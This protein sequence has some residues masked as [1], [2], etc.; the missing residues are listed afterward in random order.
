[1]KHNPFVFFCSLT[2]AAI[3]CAMIA[4]PPAHA[5]SAAEREAANDLLDEGYRQ[6]QAGNMSEAQSNFDMALEIDPT[7]SLAHFHAA[8]IYHAVGE[9]Q[10]M[11]QSWQ[12]AATLGKGTAHG[13]KAT[14]KLRD[15]GKK[16]DNRSSDLD[17]DN[18]FSRITGRWCSLK[19]EKAIGK[20]RDGKFWT[21]YV[22]TILNI[23]E[24]VAENGYNFVINDEP[25]GKEFYCHSYLSDGSCEN[26][27]EGDLYSSRIRHDCEREACFDFGYF[28]KD[29][30]TWLRISYGSGDRAVMFFANFS[31]N[32][33]FDTF[34]M[35]I[36]RPRHNMP[37]DPKKFSAPEIY[38]GEMRRCE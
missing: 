31:K 14:L 7:N 32:V 24:N 33:K 10:K 17:A 30:N 26:P 27:Y 35:E 1:M 19:R 9:I 37:G 36:G 8:D 5:Q 22:K 20:S 13:I 2:G 3:L 28:R 25:D 12:S 4:N 15:W 34:T 29:Q 6:F 11:K 38:V 23:S 21:A 18:A 16:Y